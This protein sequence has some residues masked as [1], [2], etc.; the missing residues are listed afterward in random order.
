MDTD[1]PAK[2]FY[3][4]PQMRLDGY[5]YSRT[6]I[7][8]VTICVQDRRCLLGQV[9]D[10]EM[11]LSPAGRIVADTLADLPNRFPGVALDEWMVMPN[12]VHAL[13]VLDNDG[14]VQLGTVVRALKGASAFKIRRSGMTEF[15][16][17]G[18]YYDRIMRNDRELQATRAYIANNAKQWALD[19]ENPEHRETLAR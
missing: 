4:R 11:Q 14:K 1:H 8:H 3:H 16:W 19:R 2:R 12:H 6:G 15:A 10:G 17:Q 5:D 18:Q 13:I 9:R 7:Y